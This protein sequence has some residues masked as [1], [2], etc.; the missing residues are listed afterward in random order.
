M[1]KIL[2]LLI[3]TLVLVACGGNAQKEKKAEGLTSLTDINAVENTSNRVNVITQ[4][5]PSIMVIPS[6]QCLQNAGYLKTEV[7]NGKTVYIRDYAGYILADENN[8][9][10]VR[11]IQNYFIKIGFPLNDLEQSLKALNN[12]AIMDEADGLAKDAKTLLVASCSPDIIIEFDYNLSRQAVTRTN[13]ISVFSYNMSAVDTFS[14]KSISTAYKSD[15]EVDIAQYAESGLHQ[16]LEGFASQIKNYFAD[17]ITNGREITFRV[18]IDSSSLIELTQEYNDFAETYA[19]WIREW[20]KVNAKMGTANLQRNTAK[21]MYYTNVR[22]SNIA[23][24]GTQ[25]N[26]Y[27]F[28]NAFRKEFSRTFKIKTTNATQG[29]GD[30]YVIIK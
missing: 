27:D 22:I 9:L 18:A 19:D 8:K 12:Q 11:A 21:E 7:I 10:V 26:A 14:N 24:D 3:V 28:A 13:R 30:A 25:F 4:A 29:L 17:I 15:I 6:D 5:L 23:Q 20:I 2:T 16:D 1:K